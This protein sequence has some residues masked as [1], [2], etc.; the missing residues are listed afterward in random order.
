[1]VVILAARNAFPRKASTRQGRSFAS[2]VSSKGKGAMTISPLFKDGMQLFPG[3]TGRE[4][5]LFLVVAVELGFEEILFVGCPELLHKET[6][7]RLK[8]DHII[9]HGPGKGALAA[10]LFPKIFRAATGLL[11]DHMVDKRFEIPGRRGI[12][13]NRQRLPAVPFERR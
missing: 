8:G 2:P 1:M 9:R 3:E 4:G 10:D 7:E 6:P 13:R 5:A 12:L 11:A